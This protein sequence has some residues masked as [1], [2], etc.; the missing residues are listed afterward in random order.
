MSYKIGNLYEDI[1]GNQKA[2]IKNWEKAV[3]LAP[4]SEAARLARGRL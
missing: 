3:T 1:G 4:E 2:A